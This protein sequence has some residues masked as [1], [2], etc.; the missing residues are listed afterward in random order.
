MFLKKRVRPRHYEI[1]QVKERK[2]ERCDVLCKP[3]GS[4]NVFSLN[5][6]E[7]VGKYAL[8]FTRQESCCYPFILIIT[9]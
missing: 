6:K 8:I 1:T 5:F 7:N 4:K 9:F 3:W 2:Y